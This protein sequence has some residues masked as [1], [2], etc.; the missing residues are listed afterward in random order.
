M[1]CWF[2]RDSVSGGSIIMV[3]SVAVSIE[4]HHW[5]FHLSTIKMGSVAESSVSE[6]SY[7]VRVCIAFYQ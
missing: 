1:G 6:G 5:M 2:Q 3:L 4:F 7:R